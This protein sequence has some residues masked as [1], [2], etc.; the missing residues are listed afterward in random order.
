MVNGPSETE[1]ALQLFQTAV[2]V[3]P[4]FLA[5]AKYSASNIDD[6][7]DTFGQVITA[8]LIVVVYFLLISGIEA[9]GGFLR[10]DKSLS[11]EI[12]RGIVALQ[13]FVIIISF[14]IILTFIQ[15][16]DNPKLR[17]ITLALLILVTATVALLF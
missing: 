5:A 12:L 16:L 11:I 15:Q 10:A 2:F 1:I 7:D 13:R 8:G 4:F 17:S 9:L 3:I 6:I 14:G